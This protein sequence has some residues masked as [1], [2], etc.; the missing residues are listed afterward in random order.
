[1]GGHHLP[2]YRQAPNTGPR[3]GWPG[4]NALHGSPSSGAAGQG[5]Q[6]GA[7]TAL[8]TPAR[9]FYDVHFKG[10]AFDLPRPFDTWAIE[11]VIFKFNA[12]ESHGMNAIQ[13]A[14][15]ISKDID[16]LGLTSDDIANIRLR[17]KARPSSP[18]CRWRS[19]LKL[20]GSCG[21]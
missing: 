10:G 1:M 12:A 13:A 11:N 5:R 7:W 14:V 16:Q 9:A 18:Q 6:P 20:Y 21:I 17:K 4:G 3:E 8:T 2:A 19:L 15:K